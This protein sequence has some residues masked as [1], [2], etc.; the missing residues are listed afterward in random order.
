MAYNYLEAVKN[1]IRTYIDENIDLDD[2]TRQ[3]LKYK[4]S[5]SLQN[6]D[7]ITGNMSGSYTC[8][9]WQAEENLCHNMCLLR[10]ALDDFGSEDLLRDYDAEKC[11][12]L[13]RIYLVPQALD[14]VLDELEEEGALA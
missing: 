8:N 1:D 14:E 11:D 12:C 4:L 13:I 2:W 5:D 10:D 7:S 3:R 6:E 9:T